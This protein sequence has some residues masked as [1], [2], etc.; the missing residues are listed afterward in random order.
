MY[1]WSENRYKFYVKFFV[2]I[3]VVVLVVKYRMFACCNTQGNLTYLVLVGAQKF[4]KT[5]RQG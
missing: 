2:R 1:A 3:V 4:G 5:P